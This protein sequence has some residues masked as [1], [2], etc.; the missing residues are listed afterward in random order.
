MKVLSS[1]YSVCLSQTKIRK[2]HLQ[3]LTCCVKVLTRNYIL[4]LA[5]EWGKNYAEWFKLRRMDC[6][7]SII[8]A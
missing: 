8:M 7:H 5:G 1:I 3:W 6:K 2:S 4:Y